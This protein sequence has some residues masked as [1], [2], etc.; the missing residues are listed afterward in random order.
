LKFLF[1]PVDFLP[2]LL[3]K[4]L[5]PSSRLGLLCF[6]GWALIRFGFVMVLTRDESETEAT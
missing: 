5:L 3:A 1:L 6:A 2:A 4:S